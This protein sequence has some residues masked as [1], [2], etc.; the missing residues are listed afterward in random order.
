M[1]VD[2]PASSEH[3]SE[4]S[5]KPVIKKLQDG[6]AQMVNINSQETLN[7]VSS[8]RT[9]LNSPRGTIM[10]LASNGGEVKEEDGQKDCWDEDR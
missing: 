5:S 4:K 9:I 1:E 3:F 8:A 2:S 6:F 7:N 10:D